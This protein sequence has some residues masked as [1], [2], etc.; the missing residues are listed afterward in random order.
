MSGRDVWNSLIMN[1]M[2]FIS[3]SLNENSL[4]LDVLQA[5]WEW[6][7]DDRVDKGGSCCNPCHQWESGAESPQWESRPLNGK[8]GH[9][10]EIQ[11]LIKRCGHC[12]MYSVHSVQR[13]LYKP[14]PLHTANIVCH[15]LFYK[16]KSQKSGALKAVPNFH[17]KI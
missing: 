5:Q 7:V 1:I 6:A 14:A 3:K 16:G 17:C 11:V 2:H 8:A 12:T 4:P 13:T 9:A 10:D 15:L